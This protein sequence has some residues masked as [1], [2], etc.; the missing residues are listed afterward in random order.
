M[1]ADQWITELRSALAAGPAAEADTAV[2]RAT[3]VEAALVLTSFRVRRTSVV[4]RRRVGLKDE[5]EARRRVRARR[6]VAD[7][8]TTKG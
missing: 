7:A 5:A 8:A 2:T 6:H 1:A 4:A 3:M